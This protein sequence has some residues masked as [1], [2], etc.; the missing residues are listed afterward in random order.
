MQMAKDTLPVPGATLFY[1]VDG[2]GPLLL[3]LPGGDG[4]AD[5]TESLRKQLEQRY[6]VVMY[7]R[8]GLSRSALTSP[9]KNLMIA[10]HA[11]DAHRM[12]ARLTNQPASVFSSSIGALIGLEL[13]ARHSE[14]VRTIVAHEPPAWEFLPDPE[15]DRAVQAQEDMEDTF[16]REG[17]AAAFGKFTALAAVSYEDREP[18]VV[19]APLTPQRAANMSFFFTYDSPAVRRHHLGIAALAASPTRLIFACG[20]STPEAG[21]YRAAVALAAKLGKAPVEF[22]G[23]HIGWMLRPKSCAARLNE[24]LG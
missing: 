22:P 12:L 3:I 17:I 2:S 9:P 1:R 20:R 15:R 23:D 4:D 18:D 8:R 5:S 14:Q 24:I 16:Q 6:T 7:D 21:P 10:T 11:D 13:V 19:L